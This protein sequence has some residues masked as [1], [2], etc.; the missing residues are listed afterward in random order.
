VSSFRRRARPKGVTS[1]PG[2]ESGRKRAPALA[3][4]AAFG[5]QCSKL[6]YNRHRF[7]KKRAGVSS[8]A[9]P[10]LS[11]L[12]NRF[13]LLA[14]CARYRD[15]GRELGFAELGISDTELPPRKRGSVRWLDAGYHGEMDYMARQLALCRARSG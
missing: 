8:A 6:F 15:L 12:A 5:Q 1:I 11:L 14:T 9:N 4:A 3:V 7:S 10:E 13:G 2:D